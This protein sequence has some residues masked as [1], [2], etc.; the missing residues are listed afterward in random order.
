MEKKVITPVA[1][2]SLILILTCASFGVS[3]SEILS[4]PRSPQEFISDWW[5]FEDVHVVALTELTDDWD[6][7]FYTSPDHGLAVNVLNRDS[8]GRYIGTIGSG[9]GRL[10][11]D[12]RMHG[13]LISKDPSYTL[14]YALSTSPEWHLEMEK[15][16]SPIHRLVVDELMIEYFLYPKT[17]DEELLHQASVQAME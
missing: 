5:G 6:L 3:Q 12:G 1:F 14:Y 13:S 4:H 15:Y 7:V 8:D 9:Q 11:P 10:E 17:M 16:D 2:I